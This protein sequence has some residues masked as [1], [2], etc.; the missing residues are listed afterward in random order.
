MLLLGVSGSLRRDSHNTALLR[1]ALELVPPGVEAERFEGLAL[2][3]PFDADD[4]P[5][6]GHAG[7]VAWRRAI[8][9]ADAVLFAT[10]EYNSSIPG[11]LKNAVDWASRPPGRSVLQGKPVA[12]IGAST[13][14]YGAMWAQAELRKVL[15][16]AGARVAGVE[17]AVP[18]AHE[19]LAGGSP[20][21]PLR[22]RL[23]AAVRELLA[24]A[25]PAAAAA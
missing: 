4:E 16:R 12:V 21:E 5:G 7:L 20:R 25:G 14:A 15:A 13:G 11:Q 19:Q 6:D 17:L 22:G 9:R 2:V 24:E 3:P 18:R 23:E 8:A 1:A 10:P